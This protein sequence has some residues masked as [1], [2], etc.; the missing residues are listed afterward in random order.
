MTTIL[1]KE[2]GEEVRKEG[3]VCRLC[4]VE[5]P[6]S[7]FNKQEGGKFGVSGRCKKCQKTTKETRITNKTTGKVYKTAT[8]LRT[9]PGSASITWQTELCN[10]VIQVVNKI[11]AE[12]L[13]TIRENLC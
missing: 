5:L 6:L 13:A 4:K 2:N 7:D 3:K 1:R 11:V 10:H 9:F 12:K 8:A